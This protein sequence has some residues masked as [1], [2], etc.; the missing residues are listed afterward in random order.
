MSFLRKPL[1]FFGTWGM[2]LIVLGLLVGAVA[3]YLRFALQEGPKFTIEDAAGGFTA[4]WRS[5]SV[6]VLVG[7]KGYSINAVDPKAEKLHAGRPMGMEQPP[8]RMGG[9]LS[10]SSSLPNLWAIGNT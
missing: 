6:P 5:G 10:S 7:A 2:T 8:I 4:L 3:L 1:L 9:T